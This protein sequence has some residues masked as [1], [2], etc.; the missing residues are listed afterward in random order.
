MYPVDLMKV[1]LALVVM[2]AGEVADCSTP[3]T[4]ANHKSFG[5]RTLHRTFTRSI[6][7]L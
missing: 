4:D 2:L 3:D 1:L 7:D 6:Y 5:R